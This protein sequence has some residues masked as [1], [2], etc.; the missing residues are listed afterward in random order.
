MQIKRDMFNKIRGAVRS[1][2]L[3]TRAAYY[4]KMFAA[5]IAANAEQTYE[6]GLLKVCISAAWLAMYAAFRMQLV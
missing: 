3:V 4:D 6:L 5:A 1:T 2:P